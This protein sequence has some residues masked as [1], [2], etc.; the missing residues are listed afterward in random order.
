MKGSFLKMDTLY[1]KMAAAIE[2]HPRQRIE[3]G[4][5]YDMME[6]ALTDEDLNIISLDFEMKFEQLIQELIKSGLLEPLKTLKPNNRGLYPRYKRVMAFKDN[7]RIKSEIIASIGRP[8]DVSYYLSHPEDYLKDRKY[9]NLLSDFFSK[10]SGSSWVTVN[11][12]SYEIFGDEKF[13]RGDERTR[14]RGET[15][16][17]RLGLTYEDICC[18]PT[19]EPFFC[20]VKAGPAAGKHRKVYIIENKDTFWSFKDTAFQ[21]ESDI[22][23][24][25][26]IY[27]EGRKIISS[28]QFVSEYSLNEEDDYYYFGDLDPEG[29][30]IYGELAGHYS[31][32]KIIPY[33]EG[34]IQLLAAAEGR[35][36]KKVPKNQRLDQ[37][38]FYAFIRHFSSE[39][40]QR[41][42]KILDSGG[43]IPQEAFSAEKMRECFFAGKR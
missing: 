32:C 25:M 19:L 18:K 36:I 40:G 15:I 23:V 39:H 34:Y 31:T 11:E 16:L 37:D 43:Y 33:T 2:N 20:F 27:G 8:M 14:S 41:I 26:V 3:L 38:S 22:D 30:N 12:R 5:L 24:D 35:E 9:I 7:D 13:L 29:I 21:T 17:R 42:K 1:Q 6:K 10:R 28:F 4:E